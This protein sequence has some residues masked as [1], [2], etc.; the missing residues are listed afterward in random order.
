[1]AM[2]IIMTLVM[3]GEGALRFSVWTHD[4]GVMSS[5]PAHYLS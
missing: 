3:H 5:N 1:M 2:M 4:V